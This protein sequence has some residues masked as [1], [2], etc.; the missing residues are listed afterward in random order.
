MAKGQ[1][2]GLNSTA[3]GMV[4][5]AALWL[6]SSVVLIFLYTG[7]EDL[8]SESDRLTAENAKLISSNEQRSIELVKS[9]REGGPTV[10]GLLEA[11]RSQTAEVATGDAA[12]SPATVQTKRDQLLRTIRTE[13]VVTGAE[14]FEGLSLHEALAR[15]YSAHK[16]VSDRSRAAEQRASQLEGERARLVEADAERKNDFDQRAEEAA[17]RLG[18]C[19]ADRAAYRTERDQAI[20]GLER[21]FEESRSRGTDELTKERIAHQ[22]AKKR[23]AELQKRFAAQQERLGGLLIGPETLATVRQPDGRVLAAIPGDP[24]VYIDLGKKDTL[25]LGLEFTVYA[26]KTGI[27]PD[28]RG[29]AR[30]EVVSISPEAAE[31]RIMYVVPGQVVL[32]GDLIANPVYDRDAPATFVVVGNFDLDRDGTVDRDGAETLKSLIRDWG[33][34]VSS[35]VTPLTDFVVLGV[36]PRRPRGTGDSGSATNRNDALA[37]YHEIADLAKSMSVPIL[38]QSVFLNFLG[39]ASR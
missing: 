26:A 2:I 19:E 17:Q 7:L 23:L 22:A 20:E 35:E 27:P 14:S 28:G 3:L 34:R 11:A 38:T 16:A 25:T 24:I 31:C 12:D 29:K 8:K 21:D 6:A 13:G 4:A 39:Y 36:P 30:I 32:E 9:A 37:Q 15:L 1:K 33:G 18:Q 5:F 10:V